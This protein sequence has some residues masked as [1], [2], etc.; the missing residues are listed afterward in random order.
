MPD[1]EKVILALKIHA[2]GCG[3]KTDFCTAQ[4]CPY[5]EKDYNC[6]I[7]QMCHDAAELL[8]EQDNCE[9][10]AIAIED[11]QPIVRCKDCKW[12]EMSRYGERGF[13]KNVELIR[14]TTFY[15]ADGERREEE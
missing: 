9:N 2:E 8:K 7:E 10:C 15:C 6:D 14:R 4:G 11:R 5:A 1:R 3:Y 12:F 13:C